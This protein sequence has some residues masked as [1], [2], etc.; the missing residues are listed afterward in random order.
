MNVKTTVKTVKE[1]EVLGDEHGK[2][3]YIYPYDRVSGMEILSVETTLK[4]SLS[5]QIDL[6]HLYIDYLVFV[7]AI[8]NIQV[9][10]IERRWALP[11]ED[12]LKKMLIKSYCLVKS[13]SNISKIIT[14]DM[15]LLSGFYLNFF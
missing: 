13:S 2:F 5:S 6:E 9:L 14:L 1:I 8:Y 11:D 10:T 4:D 7:S 15:E 3:I 12:M